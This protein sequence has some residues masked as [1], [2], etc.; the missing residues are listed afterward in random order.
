MGR[1]THL[2]HT[3]GS[4][5]RQAA[6][7]E[8]HTGTRG[9]RHTHDI[10]CVHVA[11]PQPCIAD[12][13]NGVRQNSNKLVNDINNTLKFA[14]NDVQKSLDRRIDEIHFMEQKLVATRNEVTPPPPPP[15]HPPPPATRSG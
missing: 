8:R 14:Q 12:E 11:A 9:H 5:S 7:H 2:S 1:Q 13:S 10:S 15:K 3:T 6:T 4:Q